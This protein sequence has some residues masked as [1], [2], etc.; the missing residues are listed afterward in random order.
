[1]EIN[2]I[3]NENCLNTM[4]KMPDNFVDLTVTS[5]PYNCGI[6]YDIHNDKM[7]WNVYLQWCEN[8]VTELYRITKEGGRIAINVLLEMGIEKNK[9]RV[10]PFAEFYNILNKIGFKPFG[11][12][13]WVDPHR[14]KHTSW[15]SWLKSTSPYI[16]CP[17]EVILIAYKGDK[18]KRE[19]IKTNISKEEFMMGCSGI[20]NLRTQTKELTKANFHEDLPNMAIKLLSGEGDL[21][22]DPFMGSGTTAK[23]AILSNRKFIGSEI[24]KEYCEIVEKRIADAN[25][26]L[27]KE[28]KDAK[29]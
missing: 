23:M 12:P 13:V 16:Y 18:W 21:V 27:V 19:G 3:Y 20:W 1:M 7:E 28:L 4:A 10:S 6:N 29:D 14:G 17:Y 25:E 9:K 15:G 8:W 5:P 24:S 26:K 2:K 11:V 22:Y